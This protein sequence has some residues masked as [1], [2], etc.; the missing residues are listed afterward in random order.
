MPDNA[1]AQLRRI[2][3][4]IP[5]LADDQEHRLTDVA[6]KIGVDPLTLIKDLESLATRFDEPGGFVEGVQLYLGS[7]TVSVV[8]NHF[9]RPMR[10]TISELR[11]VELGLTM[12]RT[13]LPPDERSC[14][15]SAREKIRRTIGRLPAEHNLGDVYAESESPGS[16]EHLSTLR[17]AFR[18]R[19]KVKLDYLKPNSDEIESRIVQPYAFVIASGSWYIIA[20]CERSDGLRIFRLDRVTGVT[21][22]DEEYDVPTSF[23]L[24]DAVRDHKALGT[25]IQTTMKVRYSPRIARWI[26]EREEGQHAGDGSFLVEHPLA[27]PDWAV[28][29]ILQYGGEAE[30]L[31]PR[32]LRVAIRERLERAA[33][34]LQ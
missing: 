19:H 22:A 21:P 30:V 16:S 23:R 15:E 11:A 18:A 7:D 31:E 10:P 1:A 29:Y 34:M 13:E 25:R 24:S 5:E 14:V 8:S 27:D 9:R 2:L 17:S 33:R 3:T 28:R 20:F 32:E 12:L 26:A 4:L 6:Q